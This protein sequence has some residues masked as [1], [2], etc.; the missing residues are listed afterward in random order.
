MTPDPRTPHD[1]CA[2]YWHHHILLRQ[3]DIRPFNF[4]QLAFLKQCM[5]TENTHSDPVKEKVKGGNGGELSHFKSN[6]LECFRGKKV[7]LERTELQVL[8]GKR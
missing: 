3:T 7:A 2:G 8:K 4:S 1:T 6:I 5:S